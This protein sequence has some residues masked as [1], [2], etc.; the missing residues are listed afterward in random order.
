MRTPSSILLACLPA[1]LLDGAF[2]VLIRVSKQALGYLCLQVM[3]LGTRG[4]MGRSVALK[5]RCFGHGHPPV[6]HSSIPA[7]LRP[8]ATQVPAGY[9]EYRLAQLVGLF[10]G[11][12]I[13]RDT[14]HDPSSSSQT[15]DRNKNQGRRRC[16]LWALHNSAQNQA[17]KYTTLVQGPSRQ[18]GSR[19]EAGG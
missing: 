13:V 4:E 2:V 8:W 15:C 3:P 6:R 16:R 7:D 18:L 1:C 9:K 14:H 19:G 10:S 11:H 17:H 12:R 5:V